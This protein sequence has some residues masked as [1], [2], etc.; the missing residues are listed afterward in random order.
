MISSPTQFYFVWKSKLVIT[1]EWVKSVSPT[2]RNPVVP[3]GST[4]YIV[5]S[6]THV[7]RYDGFLEVSI[8]QSN[9]TPNRHPSRTLQ[10]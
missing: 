1:Q 8:R 10:K 2:F 5:F 7:Y 3:K 4:G 9:D 6:G